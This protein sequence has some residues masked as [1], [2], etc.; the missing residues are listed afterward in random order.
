MGCP[1]YYLQE[2]MVLWVG[3]FLGLFATV[4]SLLLAINQLPR[5]NKDTS[6]KARGRRVIEDPKLRP[7]H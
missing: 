4:A 1:L 2:M 6:T 3:C 5:R 7:R